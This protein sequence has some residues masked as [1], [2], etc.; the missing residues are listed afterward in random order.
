MASTAKLNAVGRPFTTSGFEADSGK[1]QADYVLANP[2]FNDSDW[3]RKDDEVRFPSL[4]ASNGER[5]GVRCRNDE[6]PKDSANSAWLQHSI[7]CI[8][9]SLGEDGHLAPQGMRV[10]EAFHFTVS[11]FFARIPANSQE[12][13]T[14]ATLRATLLPKLLRGELIV[15]ATDKESLSVR[16]RSKAG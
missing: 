1:E 16:N 10:A 8:L 6:P 14:L 3:F 15:E 13:R 5:A 12:S 9:R 11:P 4:S 7:R 2:P